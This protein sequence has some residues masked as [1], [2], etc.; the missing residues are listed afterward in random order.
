M[1]KDLST[2]DN[3]TLTERDERGMFVVGNTQGQGRPPGSRNIQTIYRAALQKIAKA[4]DMTP[5]ELETQLQEV[6]LNKALEGDYKFY[7]D[8]LD[9]QHGKPV[10]RSENL[11][12]NK[13]MNKL[14]EEEKSRLKKLLND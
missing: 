9:R 5:E 12:L 1:D 10:T 8:L 14:P 7:Q 13:D 3:G 6:G 11:N 4:K 2:T